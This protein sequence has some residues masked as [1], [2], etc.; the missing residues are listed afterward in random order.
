MALAG[1]SGAEETVSF[2]EFCCWIKEKGGK[3]WEAGC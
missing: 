3:D 1:R 2:E